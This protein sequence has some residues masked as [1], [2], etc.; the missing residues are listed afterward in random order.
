MDVYHCNGKCKIRYDTIFNQYNKTNICS[1][2]NTHNN[3]KNNSE[4]SSP[5]YIKNNIINVL[6]DINNVNDINNNIKKDENLL[7]NFEKKDKYKIIKK[8]DNTKEKY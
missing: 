8:C 4:N 3:I 5:K 6:N 1:N 7:N 2:I